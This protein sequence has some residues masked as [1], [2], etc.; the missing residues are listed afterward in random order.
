MEPPPVTSTPSTPV[1]LN[2]KNRAHRA[3]LV[4]DLER[5]LAEICEDE[6]R[7]QIPH[8][9]PDFARRMLTRL[10]E[11]WGSRELWIPAS[12]SGKRDRAIRTQFNG[13]N[14]L[15]VCRTHGVSPSTVYRICGRRE[16]VA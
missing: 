5:D 12:D 15:D 16:F 1:A 9:A 14:L 10:R 7:A 13:R 6:F 4:A 8:S 2:P 3:G 11:R